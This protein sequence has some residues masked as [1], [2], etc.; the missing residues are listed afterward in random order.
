MAAGAAEPGPTRPELVIS[1]YDSPENPDYGGG[2]ALVVAELA[3]RLTSDYRVTVV[4]GSFPGVRDPGVPQVTYRFLPVHRFGPR[5]GQLL[6]H[7]GLWWAARRLPHAVWLESFTPPFSTS[8]LPWATR[9]PVVGLAQMLSGQDMTQRYHLPFTAVERVGLRQYDDVVTLN[10]VDAEL[11]EQCHPGCRVRVIPNA[12]RPPRRPAEPDGG[13]QYLLYL[14]RIDVGQKGLDLLLEALSRSDC[15]LPL[16]IA[17]RGTHAEE[18]RLRQ[19]IEATGHPVELLGHVDGEQKEEVLRGACAL[20]MPSRFETFGLC[21]LEAMAHGRPVI[22]FDLPRLAWTQDAALRV[23]PFDVQALATALD[24][25]AGDRQLRV[26]LGE[27][28][29]AIAALHGWE[30]LAD[31]YRH[32]LA[33]VRAAGRRRPGPLAGLGRLAALRHRPGLSAVTRTARAPRE[34]HLRGRA[35]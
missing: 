16:R 1:C 31:S 35:H 11:V 26:R 34:S 27:R 17:G 10:A 15:G 2:G 28:G 6:F 8:F 13:G 32:V 9:S 30:Q 5:V 24:Q 21:A 19:L 3:R 33:E 29:A 12:V 18:S 7:V 22:C 4:S 20:V 25:V 14:G 23:P